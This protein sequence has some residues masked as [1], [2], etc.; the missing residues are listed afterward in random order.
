MSFTAVD[1]IVELPLHRL[2]I[3]WSAVTKKQYDAF[4]SAMQKND[5]Q[6][7]QLEAD[8]QSVI[9]TMKKSVVP[10]TQKA[11]LSGD[12]KRLQAENEPADHRD[13]PEQ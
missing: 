11:K 1:T 8:R 13:I 3:D 7:E 5:K 9:E 2:P 6:Y 4:E 10:V 12:A